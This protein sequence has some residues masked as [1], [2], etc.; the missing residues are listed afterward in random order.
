MEAVILCQYGMRQGM[1]LYFYARVVD[2][3]I[4]L[5]V[6]MVRSFKNNLDNG[7]SAN[8]S[9]GRRSRLLPLRPGAGLTGS[10]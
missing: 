4:G 2:I 9:D 8:G 10:K 5:F 1:V 3:T 6:V 7:C